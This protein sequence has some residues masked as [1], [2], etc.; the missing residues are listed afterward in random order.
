VSS[1]TLS[2]KQ[3]LRNVNYLAALDMIISLGFGLIMPLFPMYVKLLGGGALEVGILFSSFVL[4]RALFATTFGNL[5][6]KIGRKKLIL[7][8][9]F[10]YAFLAVL[11]VVPESWIGLIFVRSLQGFASAMVWPVSEALVIDSCPSTRRGES[12]GK[13]VMASNLGM[14][15]GPFIGGAIYFAAN[16]YMGMSEESSFKL[17]FYFTALISLVGAILVWI[18]VVDAKA[19]S[20]ARQKMT[21]RKLIHPDGMDRQGLVNLRVLY[22]NAVMEGFAFSAIGPLMAYY[23]PERFGIE[24]DVVAIIVGVAMG[25]GALIAVPS[26]RLS[27]RTSRKSVF[28]LGSILSFL[29]VMLIPF[30]YALWMVIIFMSLRS[31]AFQIASPALRALQADTVP[32]QVRGRLI[33]MLESMSNFGSVLGAPIGGLLLDAYYGVDLGL[34]IIDGTMIPF[35]VS[36]GLG[37]FTVSLVMLFVKEQKRSSMAQA[38]KA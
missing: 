31:M 16:E 23:L 8:G 19:P 13:I 22:S 29:G 11:F 27:D 5:S 33:G 30:G 28:V 18:K 25:V 1:C 12:L 21:F 7:I 17:P 10:L 37:L 34:P 2:E 32:E 35:F 24:A 15:I 14:V 20:E 26:G 38:V 4:T 36:G 9:G 3:A 6:D